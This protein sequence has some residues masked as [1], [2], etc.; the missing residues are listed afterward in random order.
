[1]KATRDDVNRLFSGIDAHTVLEVLKHRPSLADLEAAAMT[2][3]GDDE[4][5]RDA[6]GQQ[7]SSVNQL[8]ELLEKAGLEYRVDA[9]AER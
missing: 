6:T 7:R 8:L 2:L 9:D 4:S 3:Q 5:M 1:M